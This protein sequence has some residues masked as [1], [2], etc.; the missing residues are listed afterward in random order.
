MKRI[1]AFALMAMT[2]NAYCMDLKG[3]A[4]GSDFDPKVVSKA[5][6]DLSSTGLD[7]NFKCFAEECLGSTAIADCLTATVTIKAEAG[8][9]HNISI[10]FPPNYFPTVIQSLVK[11]FGKPTE[12]TGLMMQNAFGMKVKSNTFVWKKG[13]ETLDAFQYVDLNNS[14][15]IL[16]LPDTTKPREADL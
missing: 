4:L 6:D 16:S 1:A 8:K 5:F 14:I 12:T 11:K 15:V 9:V 7:H 2:S 3:I 13:A 10:V